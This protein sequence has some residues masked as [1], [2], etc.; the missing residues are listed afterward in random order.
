MKHLQHERSIKFKKP[1]KMEIRRFILLAN[2]LVVAACTTNAPV[3]KDQ[4]MFTEKES[5][6]QSALF[7]Y[8][9][10][11]SME[12][13]ETLQSIKVSYISSLKNSPGNLQKYVTTR[14][15]ALNL[16][17]YTADICYAL[18]YNMRQD[19]IKYLETTNKLLDDLGIISPFTKQIVAGFNDDNVNQD[20][21]LIII[22]DSFKDTYGLL[23]NNNQEYINLLVISGSFI[24]GLYILTQIA[25]PDNGTMLKVIAGEKNVLNEIIK[26][27]ENVKDDEN[28]KETYTLLQKLHVIYADVKFSIEIDQFEKIKKETASIR[29]VITE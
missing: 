22:N 9:L 13:T 29:K 27:Y 17:V 8:P 18:T 1:R 4:E 2:L 21:I 5:P 26:L 7:A 19:A 16:G 20:S 24:E 15:K 12:V 25:P 3:N 28:L 14:E 6:S 11:T 10:P 23:H